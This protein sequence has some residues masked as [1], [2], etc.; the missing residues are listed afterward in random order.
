MGQISLPRLERIGVSMSWESAINV[1]NDQWL[2]PKLFI[3]YRFFAN[4]LFNYKHKQIIQSFYSRKNQNQKY[5]FFKSKK[6]N[7][8]SKI[9]F[10]KKEKKLLKKNASHYIYNLNNR[11]TALIIHSPVEKK[12]A[13]RNKY[14]KWY[15]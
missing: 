8:L 13:Y 3:F 15:R 12:Y 11:F 5:P 1:K 4:F 14:K 2:S 9:L 7:H 10:L 6:L